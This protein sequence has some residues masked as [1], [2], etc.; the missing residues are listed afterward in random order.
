MGH[1]GHFREAQTRK[2]E[3]PAAS[4][5]PLLAVEGWRWGSWGL[6]PRRHASQRV[7]GRLAAFNEGESFGIDSYGECAAAVH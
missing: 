2:S 1:A 6:W 7:P 3:G 5:G 4:A